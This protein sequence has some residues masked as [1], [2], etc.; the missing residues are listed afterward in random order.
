MIEILTSK[1]KVDW[2]IS[3]FNIKGQIVAVSFYCWRKP[4]YLGGTA[5]LWEVTDKLLHMPVVHACDHEHNVLIIF[6]TE[7]PYKKRGPASDQAAKASNIPLDQG[8]C[9]KMDGLS[10]YAL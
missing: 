3:H 6:A 4:K 2:V 8:S 5:D 7:T 9:I 10:S 1:R